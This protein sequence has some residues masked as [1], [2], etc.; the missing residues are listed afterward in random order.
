MD[1]QRVAQNTSGAGGRA[2]VSIDPSLTRNLGLRF[3]T[4]TRGVFDSSFDVTAVLA[5]NER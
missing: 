5:F 3:A 1:M 4:V 2:T